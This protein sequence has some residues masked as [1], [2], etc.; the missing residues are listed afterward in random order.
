VKLVSA[1]GASVDLRPVGYEY[2]QAPPADSAWESEPVWD[3]NWLVILGQVRAADGREWTFSD[4]CLTTWEAERLLEWLQAL[5]CGEV[6][7]ALTFTEPN[8]GF[9]VDAQDDERVRLRVHFSAESLP[10]GLRTADP[11]TADPRTASR[12]VGGYD[13]LL[14]IG[15]ADLAAA[16]QAWAEDCQAFPLRGPGS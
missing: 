1:D 9:R 15:R 13:V 6:R 8:L 2:E 4:P 5:G 16:A 3:A 10:P 7:K 11:R 14:A 12:R